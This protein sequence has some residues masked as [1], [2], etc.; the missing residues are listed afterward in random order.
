MN[1]I[2]NLIIQKSCQNDKKSA[3]FKWT[4]GL[5]GNDYIVPML[6]KLCPTCYRNY[7]AKFEI[8]MKILT[9]LF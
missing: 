2:P 3:C 5:S 7:H 9:C 8:D 1:R 6:S 4:Y